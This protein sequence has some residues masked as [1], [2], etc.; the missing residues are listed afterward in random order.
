MEM[1]KWVRVRRFACLA[2]LFTVSRARGSRPTNLN[3]GVA[4]PFECGLYNQGAGVGICIE[5]V[6][7]L[8]SFVRE[9]WGT[10]FND[11]CHTRRV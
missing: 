6:G 3:L 8:G 9:L 1:R 2:S 11:R 4:V 5:V 10:P 7:K